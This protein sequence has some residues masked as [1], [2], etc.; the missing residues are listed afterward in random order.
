MLLM[1]TCM[2]V[3]DVVA[4]ILVGMALGPYMALILTFTMSVCPWNLCRDYPSKSWTGN[5]PGS[6]PCLRSDA[7]QVVKLVETDFL[8]F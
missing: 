8:V 3:V 4:M 5:A 6:C 7:R 2:I 1:S